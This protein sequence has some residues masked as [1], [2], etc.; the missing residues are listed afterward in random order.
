MSAVL[1]ITAKSAARLLVRVNRVIV[2]QGD[3]AV[4][5]RKSPKADEVQAQ[6]F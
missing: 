6:G 4:N 3:V 1:C 5:F 2:R